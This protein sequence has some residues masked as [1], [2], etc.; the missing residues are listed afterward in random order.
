[1]QIETRIVFL[2]LRE[3]TA[4]GPGFSSSGPWL[5]AT[6]LQVRRDIKGEALG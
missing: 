5:L 6:R 1:M 3:D 4:P 2:L